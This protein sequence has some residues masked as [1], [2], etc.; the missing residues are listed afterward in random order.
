MTIAVDS[1]IKNQTKPKNQNRI[2]CDCYT[3]K[4][5]VTYIVHCLQNFNSKTNSIKMLHLR[6]DKISN[7]VI[8]T[9]SKGSDQPAHMRSQIRAFACGLNILWLTKQHLELLSLKGG[10]TGSSESTLVKTPN[11][12]KSGYCSFINYLA[13]IGQQCEVSD[14]HFPF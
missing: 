5:K 3:K 4:R 14:F 2:P 11:C 8:C 6:C 10:C 9:T 7:N 13:D 1:D 12:Q